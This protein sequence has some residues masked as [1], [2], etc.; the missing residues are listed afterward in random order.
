MAYGAQVTLHSAIAALFVEALLRVWGLRRPLSQVR[1]RLLVLVVPILA[2][3]LYQSLYPL[4]GSP[5]FRQGMALFDLQGWLGLPLW[6]NLTLG[7]VLLPLPVL[8]AILFFFQ[9]VI[10]SLRHLAAGETDLRLLSKEEFPDLARVVA[11]VAGIM[12]CQRPRLMLSDDG[13]PVVTRGLLRPV[14]MVSRSLA[15]HFDEQEMRAIIAHEMAHLYQRRSWLNWLLLLVRL[16]N[17]Y[18][19]MALIVF[20]RVV[21]D[22]EAVCD[23]AAAAALGSSRGLASS[24]LKA[25]ALAQGSASLD[26]KTGSRWQEMENWARL[27]ILRRRL[28]R[29]LHWKQEETVPLE[30]LRW[31]MAALALGVVLFFVV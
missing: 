27:S 11:E 22:N 6:G 9:E 2:I 23:D 7:L 25:M 10:P 26:G 24:L 14:L 21:D 8:T 28:E 3:P 19:P 1:F 16:A 5:A 29:M 20:R 15:S 17:F 12:G 31:A 13:E 30:G 4:R 18:N